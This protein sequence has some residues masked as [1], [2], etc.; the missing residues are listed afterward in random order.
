MAISGSFTASRGRVRSKVLRVRFKERGEVYISC[1]R[2]RLLATDTTQAF[3]IFS[4]GRAADVLNRN[5]SK[6]PRGKAS[7]VRRAS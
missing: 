2:C 5:V 3:R 4:R 6:K 7:P 1:E